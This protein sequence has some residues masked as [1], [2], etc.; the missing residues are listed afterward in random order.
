MPKRAH[1][2]AP[3][4]EGA[5]R[6]AGLMHGG[7]ASMR[8][9]DDGSG[10]GPSGRRVQRRRA[11]REASNPLSR[12][13]GGGAGA[14]RRGSGMNLNG[15][16]RVANAPRTLGAHSLGRGGGGGG[17]RA[18]VAPRTNV[19]Q[20]LRNFL[21]ARWNE[22]ARLL[23]LSQM[24]E[25]AGLREANIAPPGAKGAHRDIGTALWKLTGDLFPGV[26]TLSLA[27]NGLASLQPLMNLAQYVPKLENLSLER[28]ELRLVRDLD[29]L[30][31]KKHGLTHL[32]ELVLLG[33]PLQ[34]SA[35]E[36]GN[37]E[38]YR[39][40]VLA[41]FPELHILDM[42]PV[43]YVEHGFAQLFK[44]RG[45][46]GGGSRAG[47]EAANVPLRNFPVQLRP[48]FM[49]GDAGRVTPDFLSMF[50]ARFDTDRAALRHAY[51]STACFSFNLNSAAPP[52][53]RAARLVH[54]MPKQKSLTLDRYIDL[55]SR[56]ILKSHNT[57]SLL[58]S[59]H[60]GPD[61]IIAVLL[62]LP[63][64]THPLNDPSKFV[65]DAW[66]LP[67]V[68]VQAR[69]APDNCPDALLFICVHGEY[70]EAPSEGVRSFDR[71]FLVAPAMPG[72]DAAQHGWPCTIVSDELTVRH[73]SL[74]DAWRVDSL[75]TGPVSE[76]DAAAAAAA[77]AGG[78]PGAPVAGTPSAPAPG[79][80]AP[81][82]P[83]PGPASSSALP[84]QLQTQEPMPGLT[85]EQHQLSLQLAAQTRLTYPFAVQCL[86][87]NAWDTSRALA[88]F[89]A[90]QSTG[91]IPAEAFMT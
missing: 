68:D 22:P 46:G 48:G 60:Q 44:G 89:G 59:L 55:G 88:N 27:G 84:P 14:H 74:P 12:R 79:A 3:L 33:N 32:K 86:Q 29:V 21:Q 62:R 50:F 11:S 38:G 56:N 78:T 85:P 91:A 81:G 18:D 66:V 57:K 43:S 53:A 51:S 1:R 13:G 45:S 82:A 90:L 54:T 17:A 19:V 28:N 72:T 75:P 2:G 8:I 24:A 23:D 15:P 25:D 37:E 76:A 36:S 77:T 26:Q 16:A 58:R 70:A 34:R 80:A 31:S 9:D 67:N 40:D 83:A 65:V 71:T 39:R 47:A 49:D 4:L 73:Y 10:A 20:T 42:T 35:V 5:L 63:R 69:I 52:R 61:A 64:T 87:E 41:R 30:A 6:D 7:D